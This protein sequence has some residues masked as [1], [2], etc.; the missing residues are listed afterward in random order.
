MNPQTPV[1]HSHAPRVA[2]APAMIG[3]R[4][5]EGIPVGAVEAPKTLN[6]NPCRQNK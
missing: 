5:V 4:R 1:G 3:G 2:A 6:P